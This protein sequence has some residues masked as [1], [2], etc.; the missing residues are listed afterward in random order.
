MI[1]LSVFLIAS[2]VTIVNSIDLTVLTIYNYTRVFTP[3]I[4]RSGHLH[5]NPAVQ[6]Q[7]KAYPETE[8]VIDNSSFFFNINTVF[9][10]V[11][12]A[13]FGVSDDD[14][15]YLIA[16]GHDRLTSGRMP[17]AGKP[18]AVISE[19]IARN[20]KLKL[21]DV[22]ASPTDTGALVSVPVPVHVVGILS[23]PTWCSFTS[24]EFTDNALPLVPHSLLVTT[25][26]AAQTE[27]ITFGD[28]LFNQLDKVQTQ[29]FSFNSLVKD[30]RSSLASMYMIMGMVN[31]MVIFVVAL[32][33][34]MLSNIYFTQR[35]SEFAVLSAIGLRRSVL[36][37]H[38]IS[39]TAILTTIGWIA[40]VIVN[41]TILSVLRGRIFEPRGM[42]INPG[43]LFAYAYTLPIPVCIT[44]FA[45]ATITY[46]LS[47]L[48][49]VTIIERR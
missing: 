45:V 20:R 21:G 9:G 38:A 7:I 4:P 22:L 19:G 2:V 27:Q 35:I 43:D 28:K 13:C 31:G 49:P 17:E 47:R 24:K 40:G 6:K 14:R 37:W 5:V 48:D 33:A 26:G 16:R 32:M 34:G 42:L 25:R 1:I 36:I 39:E 46:R 18:E 3:V 23:G 15:A 41:Y 10:R 29:V 12:F 30:L 11:P 44:L 8:R